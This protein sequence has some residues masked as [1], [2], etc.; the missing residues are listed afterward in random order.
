M[1]RLLAALH[2]LGAVQKRDGG[3]QLELSSLDIGSLFGGPLTGMAACAVQGDAVSFTTPPE[4]AACGRLWV[5]DVADSDALIDA[6]AEAHNALRGRIDEGLTTLRRLG[7]K[8]R[9]VAPEPRARGAVA[10]DGANVVVGIDTGGDLVVDTIDGRPVS[11]DLRRSIA[12]PEEA[13]AAEALALVADVVRTS[14]RR[15]PPPQMSQDELDELQA[16]LEDD[17]D[18]DDDLLA[19]SS[20][21]A[22]PTA[23]GVP[24]PV[25]QQRAPSDFDDGGTLQLPVD[26][27]DFTHELPAEPLDDDSDLGSW[28]MQFDAR[29]VAAARAPAPPTMPIARPA[30]SLSSAP[31]APPASASSSSSQPVRRADEG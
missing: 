1:G 29:D 4:L 6:I 17:D 28:K 5:P 24:M 22:E 23:A 8:A 10:V 19:D 9:L 13:T 27:A 7:F 12:A 21:E 2:D 26:R 31:A 11:A 16:A 14:R 18:D 30:S 25:R 15:A 20:E 3:L